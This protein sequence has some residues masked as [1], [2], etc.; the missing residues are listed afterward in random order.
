MGKYTLR[1]TGITTQR[2]TFRRASAL[3]LVALALP[4][5][6]GCSL[7]SSTADEQPLTGVALCALGNTWTIDLEDVAVQVQEALTADQ[8]P[9]TAVTATGSQTLDWSLES[10]VLLTP[11]YT[12]TITT[13]PAA[14]QVLTIKQTH[15]GTATGAVYIN[16]AVAIPRKWDGTAVNITTVADNNGTTVEDLPFPV[17]QTSID[18]SVGLEITCDADTLTV[19]PRGSSITQ[20]WKKS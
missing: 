16:G 18:D 5:L 6:S 17:P 20:I 2:A 14:D 4:L 7:L 3:A 15:S 12:L 8:I 13:A 9:V 1:M 11:D 19:H 10:Q